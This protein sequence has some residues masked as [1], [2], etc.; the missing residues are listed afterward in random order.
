MTPAIQFDP[1]LKQL[2]LEKTG[3]PLGEAVPEAVGAELVPVVA[4]LV[5]ASLPIEGWETVARFGP[6]VTGRVRLDSIVTLRQHPNVAS[7]KAS[8]LFGDALAF[9]VAEIR[10]SA[11]VLR[12]EFPPTGMTGRGVV[13]GF[14][15]WGCDFAHANLR[16][17]HGGTRLLGLWDQRGGPYPD[18]PQ[19]FGYGRLWTRDQINAALAQPDPYVALGYDPAQADPDGTGTHCTHVLD[20]AAGNGAAPGAAPGVAPAADLVCVHLKGE[21]THPEDTLGDSVRVLE[22]VRFIVDCAGDRPVVINLS[23]GKTGGPHD[24][25][26]LVTQALDALVDERPGRA[27]V[28]STGNYFDANLHSSGILR[29]DESRDLPWSVTP[30]SDEIVEIEVWYS[31]RDRFSVEVIDPERRSLGT[32]PL[33]E[34]RVVREGDRVVASIFHRQHDPNNGDHQIDIF[35]WP[36]IAGGTWVARLRGEQVSD[37][38]Y[39]AWIERSRAAVQARFTPLVASPTHT[40]GTICNGLKTIAVGAYDAR[41]LSTPLAHF[42]SAGPTRDGRP[43]PVIV[44]PGVAIRAA[45]SSYPAQGG[46]LMHGLTVKSG[47][48]MAAPHVSGVIALMFEAAGDLRLSAD[49]T[50]EI[51][52]SSARLHPVD[53]Q[54]QRYGA[55]RVDAVEA[56]KQVLALKQAGAFS[57]DSASITTPEDEKMSTEQEAAEQKQDN[58]IPLGVEPS[59][60]NDEAL[61]LSSF[62]EAC[63]EHVHLFGEG[64]AESVGLHPLQQR[65]APLLPRLLAEV[66]EAEL[67]RRDAVGNFLYEKDQPLL[68]AP[69]ERRYASAA[70]RFQYHAANFVYNTAYQ[71]GYEVPVYPVGHVHASQGEAYLNLAA[72]FAALVGNAESGLRGYLNHFFEVVAT[73]GEPIP[74]VIRTGDLLFRGPQPEAPYGHVAIVIDPEL[75]DLNDPFFRER[76]TARGRGLYCISAGLVRHDA[77]ARC[78][79]ALTDEQ[80][81]VLPTR[82]IARFRDT[83]IDT[84]RVAYRLEHDPEYQRLIQRAY[85]VISLPVEA[86]FDEAEQDS[87]A[88]PDLTVAVPAFTTAKRAAIASPI[89][90]AEKNAAALTWNSNKHPAV[91]GVAPSDIRA[92]LASYIDFAAVSAALTAYNT[93]NASAPIALGTSPLDAAFVEAVHQLQKKCFAAPSQHDGKI[94][95]SALDSLGLI[96]RTGLN[97]VDVAN[98]RAQRR[99]DSVASQI[100]SSTNGEVAAA[101]WFSLM[102]NPSFLGQRFSNGIHMVLARKLRIAENSLLAQATYSGMTPVE[103]GRALGITEEHKGARPSADSNSV[104]TLGLAVDIQYTG[105]PWVVGQHVERDKDGALTPE[106]EATKRANEQCT[107]AVNRAALLVSGVSVN[108]TPAFLDSLKTRPTGEIYDTLTQRSRDLQAYLR[109]QNDDNA[110]RGKITE[111]QAAN[112][113]GVLQAGES[114]ASAV[115]RWKAM[116][117]EDLSDL[118]SA[119]S[120]FTGRNPTAGFVNLS[121][122]LVIALHDAAGLAWGAVDFGGECGDIMHFDDRRAGVGQ[123]AHNSRPPRRA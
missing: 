78:G 81:R 38:H 86:A 14:A 82:L 74:P 45:R 11:E 8:R 94:G 80:G 64:E 89:L 120:N 55:G 58:Q 12:G 56:I 96:R 76:D 13:I 102:V 68:F 79:R 87:E 43:L 30:G 117:T 73:P 15:D 37:G 67:Q 10:A 70:G 84:A 63:D 32:V 18:S 29:A 77:Q 69:N 27:V 71:L 41:Q 95:E 50:R 101:D 121:R 92:A 49:Q 1:A 52:T 24:H 103:L 36:N 34:D 53:P 9:S 33:G 42:S 22:A 57:P 98:A 104:H 122:D 35:L 85:W 116:I 44:A 20:I 90:N 93:S 99:L 123:I 26:L 106:G 107:R 114:V 72:T 62:D 97:A 2:L 111:R 51:L 115:T 83:A 4:K 110:I 3:S 113:A 21:D 39:H 28:M 23:L 6:I 60:E 59:A 118:R 65:L 19:P 5:D 16:D 46:R 119:G 75:R 105:N 47:T 112:T 31:G 88:S 40:T 100:R 61:S 108:F 17:T 109:M 54:Y 91:S 25:S 66:G 48:S 7:L